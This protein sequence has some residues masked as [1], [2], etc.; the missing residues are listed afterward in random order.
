MEVVKTGE[1]EIQ[2]GKEYVYGSCMGFWAAAKKSDLSYN[3]LSA[4]K[5]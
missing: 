5:F 4:G 3:F 2:K 1:V